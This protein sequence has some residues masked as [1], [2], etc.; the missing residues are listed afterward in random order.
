M[1][2]L[3]KISNENEVKNAIANGVLYNVVPRFIKNCADCGKFV[4]KSQWVLVNEKNEKK[5]RLPICSSCA[6]E[7]EVSWHHQW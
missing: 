3:N 6:Q 4:K 5:N 1:D 2:L 7:Y